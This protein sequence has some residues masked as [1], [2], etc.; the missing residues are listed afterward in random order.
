M[1]QWLIA[2]KV[3]AE[4]AGSVHSTDMVSIFTRTLVPGN[5]MP[6]SGLLTFQ[7]CT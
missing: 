7:I 5:L 6:S 3:L 4:D 1:P 2:L